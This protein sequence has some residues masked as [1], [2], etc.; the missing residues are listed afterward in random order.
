MLI[1][2]AATPRTDDP[3]S[4]RA[5]FRVFYLTNLP[6]NLEKL[7]RSRRLGPH[8]GRGRRQ[9]IDRR[10]GMAADRPGA[11]A[12][13]WASCPAGPVDEKGV[14]R[15]RCIKP[16]GDPAIAPRFCGMPAGQLGHSTVFKQP[17]LPKTWSEKLAATGWLMLWVMIVMVPT[18]LVIGVLSGMREGSRGPTASCRPSPSPPRPRRNMC[19]A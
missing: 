18:S 19:R 9:W 3:D 14:A 15:G 10:T 1:F 6:P 7:A 4:L 13:G 16:G 5:D 11:M 8:D 12:N 17:V 2:I